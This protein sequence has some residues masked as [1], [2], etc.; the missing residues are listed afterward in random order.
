M[1]WL[2]NVFC[3]SDETWVQTTYHSR[4]KESKYSSF[5]ILWF[6]GSTLDWPEI[7]PRTG[8]GNVLMLRILLSLIIVKWR[9]DH[10]DSH[11]V[12]I[13][14]RNSGEAWTMS[15]VSYGIFHWYSKASWCRFIIN[16]KYI[17]CQVRSLKTMETIRLGVWWPLW[18]K[19]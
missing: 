6:S 19:N 9:R 17:L 5:N 10:S 13:D 3:L 4:D 12:I 15:Q 7:R 16:S 11:E 14:V 18:H 8:G 1:N 2:T